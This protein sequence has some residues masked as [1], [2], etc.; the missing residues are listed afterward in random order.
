MNLRPYLSITSS[1]AA[2]SLAAG[3]C[4]SAAS[5]ETGALTTSNDVANSAE[6]V[7]HSALHESLSEAGLSSV[8]NDETAAEDAFT[9]Y[10][11]DTE[12]NLGLTAVSAESFEIE[13]AADATA[14]LGPNSTLAVA[15]YSAGTAGAEK[16][17]D[18]FSVLINQDS[19]FGFYPSFN[20]LIPIGDNIDFSFYGI[21]W[22]TDGFGTAQ[23][24]DLWT[25][26]GAGVAIHTMEGN[27]VIKPQIGITN[28]ALLSGGV[29]GEDDLP[30]G[31][32]GNFL[33]GIVP[34]LTMNYSDDSFE[35]EYYGGY[36]AAVRNRNDPGAAD[37]LHTWINA[38]A[39]IGP[40]FSAGAHYELLSLTRSEGGSSAVV[41]Q[42]LGP[43]VQ[44]STDN[45]F[46]ARFTA[47]A[48]I[49]DGNDGDFYKLTAGFSF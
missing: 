30:T 41:Y 29:R 48:D 1:L 35:A 4:A 25:E 13:A 43:Y 36:Y 11:V 15:Q 37:F 20:G 10:A 2:G 24:S 21:L 33:D 31:T 12:S 27:L 14:N 6:T 40:K 32:G 8:S 16:R 47:G 7:A 9:G 23:G 3:L 5:A 44:F 42:W 38:G 46:F 34:S 28:G 18:S 45:G 39:K 17:S 49:E 22:T 19:F 26:F